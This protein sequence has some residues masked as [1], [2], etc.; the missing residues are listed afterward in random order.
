MF[1]EVLL[2]LKTIEKEG[3][4][5]KNFNFINLYLPIRFDKLRTI[6][7]LLFS[8]ISSIQTIEN[9]EVFA[10]QLIAEGLNFHPDDNFCDYI[11]LETMESTYSESEAQIRNQLMDRCFEV[12]EAEGIE[13]YSVMGK[14]LFDYFK[15]SE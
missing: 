14:Y 1:L 5:N 9:D 2:W 8:M 12:C 10:Q 4:K 11:N 3:I 6:K 7:K 13:I 15:I